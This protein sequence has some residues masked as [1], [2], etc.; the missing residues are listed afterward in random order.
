MGIHKNFVCTR[1]S[2]TLHI[3]PSEALFNPLSHLQKASLTKKVIAIFFS[4]QGIYFGPIGSIKD[5]PGE[6][7]L[8]A[9][10]LILI[11]SP[12][13]DKHYQDLFKILTWVKDKTQVVSADVVGYLLLEKRADDEVRLN[14]IDSGPNDYNVRFLS[15]CYSVYTNFC[16]FLFQLFHPSAKWSRF[17]WNPT[18]EKTGGKRGRGG[19]E[20]G[21]AIISCFK[22]MIYENKCYH[23]L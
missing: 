9:W 8:D 6:V 17:F 20:H 14:C 22:T 15:L 16:L 18:G 5:P 10:I 7:L 1:R 12:D 13:M 2:C 23:F 19:R 3:D 11:F 21:N 4:H